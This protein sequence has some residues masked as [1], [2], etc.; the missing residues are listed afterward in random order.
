M[1]MLSRAQMRGVK[2]FAAFIGASVLLLAA[3][4]SLK[5]YLWDIAV[6]ESGE[7][8]RSMLFWGL[9][10]VFV[11]LGAMAAGIGL[12]IVARRSLLGHR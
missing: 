6:G 5:W 7:A 9:P 4:A 1:F 11:G 10:I 3:A 2:G 8:D 12:A